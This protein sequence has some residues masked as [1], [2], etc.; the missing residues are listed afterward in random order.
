MPEVFTPDTLA[1]HWQCS[2]DV[3]YDMLRRRQIAAFK[4]GKGWRISA[5]AVMRYERGIPA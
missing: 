3:I 1:A 2:R 4:V 5:E